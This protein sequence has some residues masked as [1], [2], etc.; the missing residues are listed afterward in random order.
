MARLPD[1]RPAHRG[2]RALVDGPA[3]RGAH[4]GQ[5]GTPPAGSTVAH[6]WSVVRPNGKRSPGDDLRREAGAAWGSPDITTRSNISR[7]DR[8][9]GALRV[10][11]PSPRASKCPSRIRPISS[12]AGMPRPRT[13]RSSRNGSPSACCTDCAVS[14]CPI[15]LPGRT[16]G[17]GRPA[18]AAR[19]PGQRHDRNRR[20]ARTALAESVAAARTRRR[21]ASGV[22]EETGAGMDRSSMICRPVSAGDGE[23]DERYRR[24]VLGMARDGA[25]PAR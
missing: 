17:S 7:K 5:D 24:V 25:G 11:A 13:P 22:H 10:S 8:G 1:Q 20:H 3:W 6:R 9:T 19:L 16:H 4:V 12:N 14:N 2:L 23:T 15:V 21:S 18:P